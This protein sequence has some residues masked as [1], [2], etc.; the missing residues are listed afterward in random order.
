M[1]H[2]YVDVPDLYSCLLDWIPKVRSNI[3]TIV[4][5]LYGLTRNN[6]VETQERAVALE[7]FLVWFRDQLVQSSPN[8]G[9]MVTQ[10]VDDLFS[11]TDY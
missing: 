6:H 9:Q 11:L 1:N 5:C 10:L 3:D 8:L 7:S 2:V 4:K